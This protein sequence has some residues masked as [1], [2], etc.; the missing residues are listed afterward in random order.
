[1]LKYRGN[2]KLINL[3]LINVSYTI[4][5]AVIVNFVLKVIP[6]TFKSITSVYKEA[7]FLSKFAK[8]Y[9]AVKG[10]AHAFD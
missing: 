3:K 6:P 2:Y 7:Y 1:L 8:E 5:Y 10:R 9:D 4:N